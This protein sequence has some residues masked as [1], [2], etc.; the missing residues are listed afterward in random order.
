MGERSPLSGELGGTSSMPTSNAIL[1][2][3][4]PG[5]WA[6]VK[7]SCV[8]LDLAKDRIIQRLGEGVTYVH[9]PATAVIALGAETVAGETVNVTLLGREG[10]LG[11]FEACGSRHSYV[12]A[13]VQ[14]GGSAWRMPAPVYRRLFG[15]CSE[16]R[17]AIH[18]YVEVLMVEAR[19]AVACNALHSVENRL[20]RTLLEISEKSQALDLPIT[21]YALSQLLGVQRTTVAASISGLQRQ[22]LIRSGRR[23][24][25][26]VK[27]KGLEAAACACR[28]T[29]AFT[30]KDIQSRTEETCDA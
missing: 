12:Q 27:P 9:F 10:A 22:G 3:L 2:C 26:I 29:V 8:L 15:E 1:A 14:I 18:K 30:R 28:E 6:S 17:Q 4:P 16:L 19:Q 13:T 7:D 20:A 21:Q 5:A 25:V 11:V 24:L 23:G